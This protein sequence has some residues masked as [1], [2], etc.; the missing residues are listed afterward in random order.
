MEKGKDAIDLDLC[1][2][3][4]LAKLCAEGDQEARTELV[5][6]YRP[7]VVSTAGRE[8]ARHGMAASMQ[9]HIDDMEQHVFHELFRAL[10]RYSSDNFGAWFH[11]VMVNDMRD[12]IRKAKSVSTKELD[13]IEI[14][15][16]TEPTQEASTLW[17]ELMELVADLPEKHRLALILHDVEGLT[18][19][20]IAAMMDVHLITVIR[21]RNR[22]LKALLKA[23]R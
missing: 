22:A 17:S 8:L 11:R 15:S 1:D 7:K 21:W 14:E 10:P 9:N 20:E 13:G 18:F 6:R 12:W 5:R 4:R 19:R 3:E 2:D 16:R 23:L